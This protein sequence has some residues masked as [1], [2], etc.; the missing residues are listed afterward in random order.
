MNENNSLKALT[1]P[2]EADD[3]F[4]I[5]NLPAFN[6]SVTSTYSRGNALWLMETCRLVYREDELSRRDFFQQN[7]LEE[8]RFFSTRNTQGA[9]VRGD[10]F[11]VL[12]FRGTLGNQDFL[13]D[14]DFPPINWPGEGKVHEGFKKQFDDVWGE[15][16][17]GLS[18]ID[19]PVFYCG[20]SLGAALATLAA[21]TRFL[22]GDPRPAALYTFGSPRVG[23]TGFMHAF[24]ADFMHFRVI[25]DRD[26]VPTVPPRRLIIGLPDFHHVGIPHHIDHE[27]HLRR[28]NLNDD[29]DGFA[30]PFGHLLERFETLRNN[31]GEVLRTKGAGLLEKFTD[32]SPVNY[33]ARIERAGELP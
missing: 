12:A 24:P 7:G 26:I 5:D 28:G 17:D 6:P 19:V 31:L 30:A 20:H 21:A 14:L 25:N 29:E 27:G 18:R 16:K 3:F 15:V 33:T 2:G 11:A 22:E 23:T 4:K 10:R 8:L 9:L 32:H 13:A 1:N